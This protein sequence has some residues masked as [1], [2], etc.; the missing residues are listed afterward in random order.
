MTNAKW[1]VALIVGCIIIGS[2]CQKLSPSQEEHRQQMQAQLSQSS[3]GD[4]VEMQD[5]SVFKVHRVTNNM[6]SL[7]SGVTLGLDE[8]RTGYG[9]CSTCA[10]MKRIVSKDD[11]AYGDL[12]RRF[13]SQ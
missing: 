12:A 9:L 4:L 13:A 10:S 11:I 1:V 8:M 7:S 2:G 3:H 6:V 5:G